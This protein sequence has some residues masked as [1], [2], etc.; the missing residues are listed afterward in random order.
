MFLKSPVCV[1]LSFRPEHRW[2]ITVQA[3]TNEQIVHTTLGSHT[4]SILGQVPPGAS[5]E[6]FVVATPPSV[7]SFTNKTALPLTPV[8]FCCTG[9][10]IQKLVA[11]F[12]V[13]NEFAHRYSV[14]GTEM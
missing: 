11:I 14:R 9:Q 5:M 7:T 6:C 4:C 10:S 3:Q 8:L 2:T 13:K 1:N 12:T